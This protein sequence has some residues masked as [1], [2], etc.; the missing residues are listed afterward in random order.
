MNA[1]QIRNQITLIQD[2]VGDFGSALGAMD[3]GFGLAADDLEARGHQHIRSAFRNAP[4]LQDLL[5]QLWAKVQAG[6]NLADLGY[7]ISKEVD[8]ALRVLKTMTDPS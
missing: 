7:A 5:P 1:S 8:E 4:E 3:R 2:A 6:E